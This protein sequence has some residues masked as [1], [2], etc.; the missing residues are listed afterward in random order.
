MNEVRAWQ[1]RPVS[2]VYPIP[3]FDA[4]FVRSRQKG[5]VKDKAVYV[6][7]GPGEA[8]QALERPLFKLVDDIEIMN[9][10]VTEKENTFA[11]TVAAGLGL[12]VTGGGDAHEVEDVGKYATCFPDMIKNEADLLAALKSGHYS[13]VAFRKINS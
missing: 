11:V 2:A 10:K 9:D 1:S 8:E 6:A 12:P 3:Y 5:P 13:P 7:A 4:I